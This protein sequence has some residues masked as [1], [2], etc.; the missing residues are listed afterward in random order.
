MSELIRKCQTIIK[1]FVLTILICQ[2]VVRNF[3]SSCAAELSGCLLYLYNGANNNNNN[4]SINQS[5]GKEFIIHW[6]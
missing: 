3:F 4:Q 2:K 1:R 6:N 5:S